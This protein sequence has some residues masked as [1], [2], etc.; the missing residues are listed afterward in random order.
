MYGRVLSVFHSILV[1]FSEIRLVIHRYCCNKHGRIMNCS[2]KTVENTV[3][4]Y[5]E[6]C[7][8][9]GRLSRI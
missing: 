4:Q 9:I 5:Q 1:M 6:I 8:S 3:V 7:K 2:A